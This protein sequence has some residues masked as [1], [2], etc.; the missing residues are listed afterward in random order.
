VNLIISAFV[1]ACVLTALVLYILHIRHERKLDWEA[2][3]GPLN[4]EEKN[5][6][7]L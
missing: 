5:R 3:Y 6:E 1:I 7:T 4:E 2:Q